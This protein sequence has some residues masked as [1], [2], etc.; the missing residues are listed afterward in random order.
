[1]V[2]LNELKPKNLLTDP[3]HDDQTVIVLRVNIH[4]GNDGLVDE[5]GY[6][7]DVD[8]R[9]LDAIPLNPD[10]LEKLGM[11]KRFDTETCNIWDM[12]DE[13]TRNGAFSLAYV[14]GEG[15]IYM[16]APG[17]VGFHSLHQLQNLYYALT[18]KEL[19]IQL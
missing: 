16:A 3:A 8:L 18:Q 4:D 11:K 10:I 19:T 5:G 7:Y 2:N 1:M 14:Q 9:T 6:A 15:W 13:Q 12:K 17:A